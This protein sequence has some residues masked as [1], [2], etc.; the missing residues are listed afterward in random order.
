MTDELEVELTPSETLA[1]AA[2]LVDSWADELPPAPW[3][4]QKIQFDE[5][6]VIAGDDTW[7][8]ETDASRV[9]WIAA[10]SPGFARLLAE[11]LREL[12]QD[13]KEMAADMRAVALAEVILVALKK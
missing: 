4:P 1:A 7:V 11:Y 10:W 6:E 3:R 9:L 12:A 5:F 13:A 2:D 8:A